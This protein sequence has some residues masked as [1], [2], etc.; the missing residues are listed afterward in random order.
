MHSYI[1]QQPISRYFEYTIF[2]LHQL[3]NHSSMLLVPDLDPL[4]PLV[5]VELVLL[6][7]SRRSTRN[8]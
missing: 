3:P 1:T 4:L 5:L 8:I 2:T 6:Q 7:D